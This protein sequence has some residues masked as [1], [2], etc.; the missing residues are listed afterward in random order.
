MTN[1]CASCTK[2]V[3]EDRIRQ[4]A[5]IL[6]IT[7]QGM[8]VAKAMQMLRVSEI[9]KSASTPSVFFPIP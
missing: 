7:I 3:N 6:D 9:M 8:M 2:S 4:L 1:T 5:R